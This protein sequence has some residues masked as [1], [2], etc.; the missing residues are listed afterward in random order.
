MRRVDKSA[1]RRRL[2]FSALIGADAISLTG[3]ALTQLAVPWFVLTT[4]GS[5]ARTGLTAF[6][7][8]LPFILA[9]F[10]GGAVVDRLGTRRM[11]IVADVASM[12][13][14]AAIPLLYTRH[15]LAFWQLLALV[16]LRGLLDAPG[17]TARAAL[18]PDMAAL[19][20]VSLVRANTI[21]EVV[22]SGSQLTGPALA[23]VLVSWLGA[24]NVLW[25]DAATFALSAALI[26][27]MV[28]RGASTPEPTA[29]SY[30][31]NLVEGLRFVWRDRPIRAIFVSATALNFLIS[32]LLAVILP[33]YMKAAYNS[34]A[35]LG[36]VIA[37]FGGGS[38]IGAIIYGVIGDGFSRRLTFV[39]GVT[40]IGVAIAILAV[41]PPVPV[42]AGAMLLGGVISGPNGPLVST[43]LQERTPEGLRGRVWGT[44]TAIGFAAAPLGVVVAGY[45]VDAVGVRTTLIGSAVIFLGVTCAL[46]YDRGLGEMDVAAAR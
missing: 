26:A 5:A 24:S 3:N 14:V 25:V 18:I 46:V 38:V 17:T 10:L 37:A 1:R 13:C 45:V 44:T 35:S 30:R 19:A 29:R 34:A 23:G 36:L 40:G 7:G 42:M 22:E 9:A 12:V 6:C 31:Q 21:H 27:T 20:R 11:S 41:L 33:V 4:T 43:V 15:A 8:L 39:V 32:P 28:P 2:P 16:F